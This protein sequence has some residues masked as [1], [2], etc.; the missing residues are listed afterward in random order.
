M[1]NLNGVLD[2]NEDPMDGAKVLLMTEFPPPEPGPIIGPDGQ[3]INAHKAPMGPMHGPPMPM[4]RNAPWVPLPAR[5]CRRGR[6]LK[7]AL[8]NSRCWMGG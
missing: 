6:C 8:P 3:N 1:R 7:K 5:P 4:A 2:A